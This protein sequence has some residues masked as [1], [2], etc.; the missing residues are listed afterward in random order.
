MHASLVWL[1]AKEPIKLKIIKPSSSYASCSPRLSTKYGES[2]W[3]DE[4]LGYL[5]LRF[6]P[7]ET[8]IL[9]TFRYVELQSRNA[10]TF[11][12]EFSSVI[13]D[14]GS[15]FS[16]ILDRLVRKTTEE[17][18]DRNLNIT[19]YLKFLVK[20][21]EDI[22]S[23]SAQLNS[24]FSRNFVLPFEG[25]RKWI[26]NPTLWNWWDA[27][28]KLK[29][30]EIDNYRYGSLTNVIYGMGSLA[31]LYCLMDKYRRAEGRLFSLIGERRPIANVKMALFPK[32]PK[33]N[34]GA[35]GSG[36]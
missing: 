2:S 29:H 17:P 12:Y 32:Q 13:R 23:I 36:A 9:N 14:I 10:A 15:S 33:E 3:F 6:R 35:G 7:I 22:E 19:D 24:P 28:N 18:L 8:R 11:S 21:V 16:S 20:E 34:G 25:I 27:Y 5:I 30:L 26:K 1:M 4:L 31:I